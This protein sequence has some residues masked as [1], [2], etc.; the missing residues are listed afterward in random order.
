LSAKSNLYY[1]HDQHSLHNNDALQSEHEQYSTACTA[2]HTNTANKSPTQNSFQHMTFHN[3]KKSNLTS[4]AAANTL[5]TLN[6]SEF[7]A[8]AN[9][10]FAKKYGSAK[11]I[12]KNAKLNSEHDGDDDVNDGDDDVDYK[13]NSDFCDNDTLTSHYYLQ[14][15][16]KMNN[17]RRGKKAKR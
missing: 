7:E 17:D 10:N 9:K 16:N 6:P 11:S 4:D 5:S 14:K 8:K 15:D 1:Y 12:K 3:L 2:Q 13:L